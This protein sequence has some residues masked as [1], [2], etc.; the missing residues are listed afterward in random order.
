MARG[1]LFLVVGPSGAGK[2]TLIDGARAALSADPRF[3]F[4]KRVITRPAEAGG[5]E[6]TPMDEQDFEIAQQRGD[7][8]LSWSAHGLHYGIPAT[9]ADEIAAGRHVVANVSRSVIGEA[10]AKIPSAKT[11]LVTAPVEILAE[12]LAKRGREDK[13][14]I[15]KRLSRAGAPVPE[16]V[17]RIE[18]VNDGTAE[19]GIRRFIAALT[20]ETLASC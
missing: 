12:R 14:D 19:D 6:H 15:L 17:D 7:F 18:V 1:T 20:G 2:D 4:A 10:V 13:A 5:E 3:V 16:G 9:L 11:L 8:L